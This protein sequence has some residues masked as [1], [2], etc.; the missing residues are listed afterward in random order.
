MSGDEPRPPVPERPL[1]RG[2]KVWLRPLEERDMPAYVAGINDTEVGGLAGY[3][4]PMSLEQAKGWLERV[5]ET[6][7]KGE[8]FFFAV[9]ELGDDR[10]VG[11]TWL[12]EIDHW[13]GNAELAIYMDR[14][15]IGAGFGTDAQRVL[16]SFAFNAIGLNRVWLT[17]YASNPRAIRSYEKLGFRHEG[18]MRQSW[19][20]AN[21]LEDSVL[22][23]ILRDEWEAARPGEG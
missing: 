2:E 6:W 19:R 23:A 20:G 3:K 16:L 5:N 1:L 22:M 11:T 8:G 4:A 12:K 13:H 17:A 9:C 15:H 18:L 21:G 10:F 14:D 7:K